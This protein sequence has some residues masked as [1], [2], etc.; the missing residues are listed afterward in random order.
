[1]FNDINR[2]NFLEKT[3]ASTAAVGIAASSLKV[4]AKVVGANERVVI[5][6]MG[7]KR[8]KAL[9]KTFAG[10]KNVEIK[11]VCEVDSVRAKI[12]ADLVNKIGGNKPIIV[13]D[14]RK[15][16]DDKSVDALVCAAPNHWHGPAT[17]L[18]C[19]AGKHVY[20][21]K[22]CC[23]NPQEGE[24]MIEAA[25][26]NNR[27]VQVGTQRRSDPGMI[28]SIHKLKEGI[29]GRIFLVRSWYNNNR[30]SIGTGK[31]IKV[32]STLDFNLWQGPAPRKPYVNN[33]VPYNWHWFWHWGNGE[34][35][36]NGVH[37]LDI[38]RW[39][40]GVDYPTRVTSS[41]G[42]YKWNDDQQTPDTQTVCYQFGDK[43]SMTWQGLSCS[44][45]D[46]KFASFYGEEGALDLSS[47]GSYVLYDK[48]DKKVDEFKSQGRGDV[49][50]IDN[51]LSAI[52]NDD[53]KLLN[54]DIEVNH[55]STMLC[56]LGNIA[57]RT[58]GA[59][60]FDPKTG[61]LID[62]ADAQ[63]YWEREYEP[64]WKPQV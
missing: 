36:N 27:V 51:F 23:H 11:Y 48:S 55:V 32:P 7:M 9:A 57:Q 47:D 39:A 10:R 60:D 49:E 33:L 6:V 15:V 59:V 43:G 37:T 40:M 58:G 52:R 54:A 56:H 62:N 13:Q 1:M 22:P 28:E 41:G 18:A 63:K 12:G 61:K 4:N 16:L 8:G 20:V 38:C 21:E 50:H 34:L 31:Q 17:I 44:R 42:R 25:R 24:W 29:I 19:A 30:Q 26:K 45:H 5:A 53:P 35:G 46:P 64:G 2:R 14:F 3:I